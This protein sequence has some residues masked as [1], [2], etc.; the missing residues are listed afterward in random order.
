MG[1]NCGASATFC[2]RGPDPY[3]DWFK[4]LAFSKMN[5]TDYERILAPYLATGNITVSELTREMQHTGEWRDLMIRGSD[6][7]RVLNCLPDAESG[8]YN[9]TTLLCLGVLLC[10]GTLKDRVTTFVNILR[11]EDKG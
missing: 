7:I 3:H 6:L 10:R 9:V 5:L 11:T 4:K 2:G 1:C 8:S